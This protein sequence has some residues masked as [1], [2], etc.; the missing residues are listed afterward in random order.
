MLPIKYRLTKEKDFE[1][2]YKKGRNFGEK[3]IVCKAARNGLDFS[4]FGFVI[5]L[6]IEK[7][8]VARNKLRRQLQ[9]I[10]RTAMGSIKKGFDIVVFPKKEAKARDYEELKQA[11]LAALKK[12]GIMK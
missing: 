5:G 10:A 3:F 7:R 8:A 12:A 6:K 4:R 1:R 2:A 11:F 9:E